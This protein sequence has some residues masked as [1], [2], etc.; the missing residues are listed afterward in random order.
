MQRL[1]SLAA[2]VEHGYPVALVMEKNPEEAA[3]LW[4][5]SEREWIPRYGGWASRASYHASM[6]T[7]D[8]IRELLTELHDA[9]NADAV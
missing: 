3:V 8:L 1:R 7:S 9:R 5:E 4:P 2:S 6:A